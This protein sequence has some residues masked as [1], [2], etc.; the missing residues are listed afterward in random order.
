MAPVFEVHVLYEKVL[1]IGTRRC[2]RIILG[3]A[4]NFCGD[5]DHSNLNASVQGGRNHR[6]II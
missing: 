6:H 4:H 2:K 5:G 1:A 3:E